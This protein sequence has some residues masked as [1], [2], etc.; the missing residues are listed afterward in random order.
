MCLGNSW[1]EHGL[2]PRRAAC[3]F[4]KGSETPSLVSPA[5]SAQLVPGRAAFSPAVAGMPAM[6]IQTCG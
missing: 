3:L 2:C 6:Q 1:H 5:L 4:G